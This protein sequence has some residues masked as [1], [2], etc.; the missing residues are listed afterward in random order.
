MPKNA[1]N[2]TFYDIWSTFEY[3]SEYIFFKLSFCILKFPKL[4][5][6]L[7]LKILFEDSVSDSVVIDHITKDLLHSSA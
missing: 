7:T 1:F 3:I 2:D 5:S 6:R 4:S